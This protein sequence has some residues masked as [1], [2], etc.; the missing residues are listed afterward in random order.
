MATPLTADK[1]LKALRDEGLHVIEHR[2]WRTNNRNH[3]GPWGP[4]HGVM[5]HHTVTSGT[6]NSVE[7]CYNGHSALPGPLC[8]GVIDKA[9]TVHLVGNG[10][11]NHAGLGDDDVLR[12]VAAEA[13]TLP[14]D[15]EANTDGNRHFYGFECV[16]LGNGQDPWPAAQL[17]AIERAAA[18]L[19]RAHGWSE[20]SV[21]GH[22]EWQPGKVD[23][24]GFT[25]DSMRGRIADRLDTKTPSKPTTPA[26]PSPPK[27]PAVD[28]SKLIAAA[29][30]NP[31]AKGTPVTYPGV[32]IVEA[33]LVDAGYL[34]KPL[35]DGHFGTATVTAY[36]RWQKSK[37]GGSYKGAA[38]DGIPGKDSLTRL[39]KRAGFTVTP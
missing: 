10:R 38:A 36:S 20:R 19:C 17:E 27:A 24:R 37:A 35:L 29:R 25:M 34:A 23:P 9:G 4:T 11:T 16:N 15:N 14:A 33:A 30:S 18:A 3:K 13:K 8:H 28:L 39:G 6:A 5:I 26:L 21:I 31:K 12:A 1:L 7:L 32:R 2:S 22:L